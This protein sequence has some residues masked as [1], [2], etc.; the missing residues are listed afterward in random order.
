M[1][2]DYIM[3]TPGGITV[4]GKTVW[5]TEMELAD[6][7][8]TTVGAV[9]TAIKRMLKENTLNAYDVCRCIYLENGNQADAYNLEMILAL[10]FLINTSEANQIRKWL[11]QKVNKREQTSIPIFI[12]TGSGYTC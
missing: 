1:K 6:L 12:G 3:I 8:N 9:R 5:M 11:V 7:F 10:S 4:T 2:R